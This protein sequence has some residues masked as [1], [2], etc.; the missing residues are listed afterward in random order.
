V[1]NEGLIRIQPND[2]T[3]EQAVLRFYAC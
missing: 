3:A 1:E 2:I